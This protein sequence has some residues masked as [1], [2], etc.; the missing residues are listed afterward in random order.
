MRS[1]TTEHAAQSGFVLGD[2]V[3]QA[4][5]QDAVH[6]GRDPSR[7]AATSDIN[8]PAPPS[9]R[10][11]GRVT[12]A[13]EKVAPAGDVT[14]SGCTTAVVMSAGSGRIPK[15][16]ERPRAADRCRP[17]FMV[18]RC[19]TARLSPPAPGDPCAEARGLSLGGDVIEHAALAAV[20][21]SG[22]LPR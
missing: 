6:Q 3:E 5:Q 20:R 18:L 12:E 14:V 1:E 8:S 7:F 10:E 4:A 2:P 9:D 19:A 22:V 16:G 13:L 11:N 17:Q 21:F 15:R